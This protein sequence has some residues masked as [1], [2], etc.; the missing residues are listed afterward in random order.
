MKDYEKFLVSVSRELGILRE[1][2]RRYRAR[3]APDFNLLF[4][5]GTN[6]MYL[7]RVFADLLDPEGNHGQGSRFL[8]GFLYFLEKRCNFSKLEDDGHI[9]GA[10]VKTEVPTSHIQRQNRR[11]DV[12]VRIPNHLVLCI[13]NK[14][15]AMDQE[16]QIKDYIEGLK[17]RSK[18][19]NNNWLILYLSGDGNPPSE[20]SIQG[21]EWEKHEENGNAKVIGYSNIVEWLDG[22]VSSCES[23]RVRFFLCEFRDY[24]KRAFVMRQDMQEQ[25]KIV[26]LACKDGES[27][28]AAF[29]I[30]FAFSAIKEKLLYG[31]KL[32]LESLLKGPETAGWKLDWKEEITGGGSKAKFYIRYGRDDDYGFCLGFQNRNYEGDICYGLRC[33]EN[34]EQYSRDLSD[35]K[36]A[37]DAGVVEGRSEQPY[38]PWWVNWESSSGEGFKYEGFWRGMTA[39]EKTTAESLFESAKAV[40]GAIQ[41]AGLL[42][43][44]R[45][46]DESGME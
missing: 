35:V 6:E 4:Y 10:S 23:E 33:L 22:C 12:L 32:Q 18:N 21:A 8:K 34:R 44:L 42:E 15:W 37:L 17:A 24:V 38:W 36:G 39:N 46:G 5:T 41:H 28:S 27:L 14:P 31:L 40:H 7:S 20:G 26:G 16:N 1:A 25:D 13:E 2:R 11:L 3:L 9:E 43:R 19:Y 30:G 45:G 29:Q